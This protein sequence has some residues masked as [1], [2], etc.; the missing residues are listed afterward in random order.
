MVND[1]LT[2]LL[3]LKEAARKLGVSMQTLRRWDKSE[4]LKAVRI[5]VRKGVGDRRYKL[6]DIENYIKYKGQRKKTK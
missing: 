4:H 5:G 1:K 6:E 2:D 3:T